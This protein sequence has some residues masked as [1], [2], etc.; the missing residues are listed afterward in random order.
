M[1]SSIKAAQTAYIK[2][3]ALALGFDACGIAKAEKLTAD[4]TFLQQWLAEGKQGEMHYMERNFEKR[5]DPT[6]LVEGCRSVIV[7]L[8]HYY[9]QKADDT[10]YFRISK[11]AQTATDY[12]TEMKERLAQL[13]QAIVKQYGEEC[14]NAKQQHRFV[15]SAPILER[16]WA[17]RAGLGWIGKNKLLIHPTLGSYVFIGI[18]L[19]NSVLEYDRPMKERCGNCMR[20]IEA[21]PTKALVLHRG[22]DANKCISYQTIEKKGRIDREIRPKLS[23]YIFGCDICQEVCPWNR[24]IERKPREIA[25][26]THPFMISKNRKKWEEMTPEDFD[27]QFEKTALKRTG[28]EK[29]KQNIAYV[30]ENQR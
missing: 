3:Q 30:K 16:R 13:E 11:Y 4:A 14:F 1:E 21:C 10:P 9:Q 2:K 17:E 5:T 18:L 29:I 25:F 26:E 19:T 12:H 20:C 15:D 28:Y 22:L 7:L 8:M 6:R 23:G 24:K 27:Q